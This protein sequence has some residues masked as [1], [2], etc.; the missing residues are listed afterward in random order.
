MLILEPLRALFCLDLSE[1]TDFFKADDY[2]EW[3]HMIIDLPSTALLTVP[4]TPVPYQHEFFS[5]K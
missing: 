4:C 2:E 5:K 3:E 1:T